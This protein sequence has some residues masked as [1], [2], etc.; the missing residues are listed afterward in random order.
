MIICINA[1]GCVIEASYLFLYLFYAPN[2]V[3]VSLSLPLSLFPSFSLINPFRVQWYSLA[4]LVTLG[5]VFLVQFAIFRVIYVLRAHHRIIRVYVLRSHDRIT[6][7]D[8]LVLFQP[9]KA[10]EEKIALVLP[11]DTYQQKMMSILAFFIV[12][13]K[14]NCNLCAVLVPNNA[15][16][17]QN[18]ICKYRYNKTIY[19]CNFFSFGI[20]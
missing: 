18:K 1:I 11:H 12:K 5:N 2:K 3:K 15:V 13:E 7:V 19:M 16:F 6:N 20:K 14:N 8:F 10:F 9:V 4:R 17:V